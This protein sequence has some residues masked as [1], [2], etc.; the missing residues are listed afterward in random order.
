MDNEQVKTTPSINGFDGQYRFLSNFHLCVVKYEGLEYASSEAAYQAAKLEK[1]E[2][3]IR[4]TTMTPG[5]AKSEGQRVVLR[6]NWDKIKDEVMANI[7]YAKF[8]QNPELEEKLLETGDKYLEET[9][10]WG[11]TYWGVCMGKGL[12]KL[13][14]ILMNT[15]YR[16]ILE[17]YAKLQKEET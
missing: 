7:V 17:R 14:K 6:P 16:I 10:W 4:F 8:T 3:R 13:G 1:K 12:N 11:D 9:N 5:Q 15:R 2:D